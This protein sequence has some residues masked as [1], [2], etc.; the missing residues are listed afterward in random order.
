MRTW[1]IVGAIVAVVGGGVAFAAFQLAGDDP[2]A[3]ALVPK[4]SLAYVHVTLDPSLDQKRA[5]SSLS[6][7]LPKEARDELGKAVG[8]GLDETLGEID[9]DFDKDIKPWL[10][11]EVAGF[12][13][14][15]DPEKP[16]GGVVVEAKDTEAALSTVRRTVEAE[17]G[18]PKE[19]THRETAYWVV[20]KPE[21]AP[22]DEPESAYAVVDEFL[23]AGTVDSVKGSIDAATDG[24]LDANASYSDLTG[25][26]DEDRLVTYWV[27]GPKLFESAVA[28]MPKKEADEFTQQFGSSPL[29][30]QQ[31][32]SAGAVAAADD[33]IV[34]AS[35][36][37]KPEE[38]NLFQTMPEDPQFAGSL[39]DDT[40]FSVVVPSVGRNATS[41][42][43][44]LPGDFKIEDVEQGVTDATGLDLR[45][46]ILD[47][48][49]DAALFVRG[50]SIRKL[51]GG[52][53]IKSNDPAATTS[54]L[55]RLVDSSLDQGLA[56]RP[57]TVDGKEGFELAD[58]SV[59]ARVTALGG[60]R[61]VLAVD[62]PEVSEEDSAVR[63]AT[64]DGPTLAGTAVFTRATESLGEEFAPILFLDVRAGT[65][66]VRSAF[67]Q[68]SAPPE[69][70]T[71]E[72]YLKELSHVV[73][74][75]R[76]D[77]DYVHQRLVIGATAK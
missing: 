41:L 68:S 7:R 35:V 15:I 71:A 18:A 13:S 72:K 65:D 69:F 21:D 58:A 47:W 61:L 31:V 42:L 45:G 73:G 62:S 75:T 39:P 28:A 54:A 20:P 2:G 63:A 37:G 23:V 27:D 5:L 9:L 22:D 4:D 40:W 24:G 30:G 34:F 59:P 32:P 6:Q 38:A 3:A 12:I 66:V 57:T 74:G 77:G 8:K 26:L 76:D 25:R 17:L 64:G 55:D 36:S 19:Q 53:V 14:S 43:D 49:E 60:E 16:A 70:K 56:V 48:M 52:L 44:S 67:G 11:G 10:G 46:D 1:L 29:F 33:A 51:G 50:N